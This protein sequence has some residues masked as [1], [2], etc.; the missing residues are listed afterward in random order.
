VGPAIDR[1]REHKGNDLT[2]AATPP[3]EDAGPSSSSAT[4]NAATSIPGVAD[5]V[6]VTAY[7]ERSVE[8]E[9]R[10]G[11]DGQGHASGSAGLHR[12]HVKLVCSFA[13]AYRT[14]RKRVDYS[15]Y[16]GAPLLGVKGVNI[17]CHGR[18]NANA[19]KNAIRVAAAHSAEG[20]VTTE[21]PPSWT[22]SLRPASTNETPRGEDYAGR[23]HAGVSLAMAPGAESFAVVAQFGCSEGCTR[24]RPFPSS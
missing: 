7:S 15:E 6:F 12:P 13:S 22:Q 9:R 5:V 18:S 19:I 8:S 24:N 23:N 16:G 20:N 2:R 3:D 21:S 1:G 4:S 14:S 10:S 17:I 11:G